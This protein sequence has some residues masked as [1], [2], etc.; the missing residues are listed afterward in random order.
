LEKEKKSL[1]E[2]LEIS[3]KSMMSEHGG[4]E[5]KVER[6]LEENKDTLWN[7]KH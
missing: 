2:K 1:H 4:L 3:E 7:L 6:L 5:K